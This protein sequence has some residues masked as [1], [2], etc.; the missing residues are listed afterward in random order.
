M[1]KTQRTIGPQISPKFAKAAGVAK[2][3]LFALALIA[4]ISGYAFSAET[5]PLDG[6]SFCRKV[7]SDGMFGQSKG[8]RHHCISFD[9]GRATDNAN[10]FFG[11]PP[12]SAEYQVDGLTVKFSRYEY[13]LS[14]DGASLVTVKGSAT[15]GTVLTIREE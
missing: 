11:N 7:I 10:T 13:K 3:A 1:K 2:V 14:E 5:A 8:E 12:E 6:K 4:M 9:E 15:E